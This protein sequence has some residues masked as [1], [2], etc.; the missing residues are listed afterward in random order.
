MSLAVWK[1]Y[2]LFAMGCA[3]LSQQECNERRGTPTNT[4][5]RSPLLPVQK[6][7]VKNRKKML[8]LQCSFRLY[9]AH[10]WLKY[11]VFI[12]T[13]ACL[14]LYSHKPSVTRSSFYS[15]KNF[16]SFML[17]Y[18]QCVVFAI[19]QKTK[20]IFEVYFFT[21]ESVPLEHSKLLILYAS[22]LREHLGAITWV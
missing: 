12:S 1:I 5:R 9:V 6:R 14:V 15:F 10:I 13:F 16:N 20:C 8:Q 3:R 11:H 4:S 17:L 19:L 7:L 22:C 2:G 18:V 21:L